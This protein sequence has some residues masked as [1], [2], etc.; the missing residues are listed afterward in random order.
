MNRTSLVVL[1]P[2]SV[3]VEQVLISA[4]VVH[5]WARGVFRG[6]VEHLG[7]WER[8]VRREAE[9]WSRTSWWPGFSSTPQLPHLV[10]SLSHQ[11]LVLG[12]AHLLAVYDASALGPRSV[13]VVRVLLHVQLGE[14]TLLLVVRLLLRVWHGLPAR[15][16]R[17][18]TRC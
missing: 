10:A 11:G 8:T 7:G 6:E 18:Q 2:V 15:S 4:V 13:A 3:S 1:Q 12:D 9:A 17:K 14:S 5:A 16:C